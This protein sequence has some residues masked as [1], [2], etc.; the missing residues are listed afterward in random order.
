MADTQL[1]P[2]TRTGKAMDFEMLIDRAL[3]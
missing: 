1:K 3:W 2:A